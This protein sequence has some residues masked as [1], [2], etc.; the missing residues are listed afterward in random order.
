[1]AKSSSMKKK[2]RRML[3]LGLT[4]IAIIFVM[5]F[6]IGKYWVEIFEKYQEKKELDKELTLLKEKEETLKVDAKKLQNPD[7]IARYAREKYQYSKDGEFILQIPE[8]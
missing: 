4:S 2:R 7:Y 6:T 5:T 8:E 3:F 1:M